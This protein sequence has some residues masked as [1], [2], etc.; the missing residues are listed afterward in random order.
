MI[1]RFF[2]HPSALQ[3][4]KVF[5][6]DKK[7]IHQ[8]QNVL[9]LKSGDIVLLFDG[10]GMEYTVRVSK[11]ALGEIEGSIFEKKQNEN[12]P[13]KRA[14]LYQALPKKIALFELVLQKATEIGVQEFIPLITE[15]TE[16]KS[17]SHI[18]RL[19]HI[20]QEASEQSGRAILPILREPIT[21]EKAV[22]LI[23]RKGFV[24]LFDKMG[25]LLKDLPEDIWRSEEFHI[26]IGPEGGFSEKELSFSREKG[27][28]IASFGPLILRTETAGIV[29]SAILLTRGNT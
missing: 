20:I 15:R 6:R 4:K 23:K 9:R 12:E 18:E 16:R 28:N 10:S 3:E 21:L 8:I 24:L 19:Q 7:L 25:T 2:V 13:K 1:P 11:M 14:V 26:F 29:A 22:S 5:L 17:L 27:V